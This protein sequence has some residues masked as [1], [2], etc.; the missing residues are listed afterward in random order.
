MGTSRAIKL[1]NGC[2]NCQADA[3]E[4]YWR[5]NHSEEQLLETH[6]NQCGWAIDAEGNLRNTGRNL[7][8]NRRK[9]GKEF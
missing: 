3:Y 2:P 6:C 4:I 9:R 7:E 8:K 1:I 5:G